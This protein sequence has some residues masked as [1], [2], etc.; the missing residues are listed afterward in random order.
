MSQ[1]YNDLTDFLLKHRATD[2]SNITHTRIGSKN[3]NIYGGSYEIKEDEKGIF[4]ELYYS[5]VLK[6]KKKEYLTEK[7]NP[8]GVLA[9]D[10][11]FRFDEDIEERQHTEEDIKSIIDL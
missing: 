10:L 7:Q 8:D 6:K 5:S 4:L 3:E 2:K 1:N 11:D 9:I